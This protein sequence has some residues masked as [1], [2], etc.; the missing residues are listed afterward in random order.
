VHVFLASFASRLTLVDPPHG[1]VLHGM[2]LPLGT[3]I[4]DTVINF[5]NGSCLLIVDL[6]ISE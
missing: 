2:S 4:N 5:F 6:V 3:V 1:P